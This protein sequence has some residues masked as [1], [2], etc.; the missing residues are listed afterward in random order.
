MTALQPLL[1]RDRYADEEWEFSSSGRCDW[2]TEMGMTP[3]IKRCGLPSSPVS[4]YRWCTE[5]DQEARETDPS[6]YGR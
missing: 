5:H 2:I 4:F 3:T 1:A 6:K